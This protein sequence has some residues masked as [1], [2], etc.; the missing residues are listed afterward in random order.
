MFDSIM[1]QYMEEESAV[2]SAL[3]KLPLPQQ[4]H[5]LHHMKALYI[6]AHGSSYNAARACAPFL[7]GVAK[8]RVYVDTPGELLYNEKS[9]DSEDRADTYVLGISQTGT[10]S[11]V[12]KAMQHAKDLGFQTLALSASANAPI[13]TSADH[14]FVLPCQEE[15]SNAKTKGYS[16]TLLFLLYFAYALAWRIGQIDE[17]R[18][19]CFLTQA[20]AEIETLAQV[21]ERAKRWCQERHYGWGMSHVYVIGNGPHY[22]SAME[23]MLKLMETM[24][25]PAMFSNSTEFSHGMH[26][27]LTQDSH[28]I[29]ILSEESSTE[30]AATY[31]YLKEANI[32]V[33]MIDTLG[34]Q[35]ADDDI[36]SLPHF[37]ATSS[38]LSLTAVLQVI[39]AFVPEVN[40]LD[41]NRYAHDDYTSCMHTRTSD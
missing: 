36:L 19:T 7:A 20:A 8:I 34:T 16:A 27:S 5:A 9:L 2:L 30:M 28:V 37:A 17:Q 39:A 41:P 24:C 11:G 22:G 14:G 40:G 35:K 21:Q 31:A 15:N 1:W 13:I 25:I 18:Y 3:L 10:S 12:L 32:P 38:L 6:T 26:R 29:L 23:G 33:V 4:L